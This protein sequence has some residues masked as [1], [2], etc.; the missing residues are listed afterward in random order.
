MPV[1]PRNVHVASKS[2]S[3]VDPE[4]RFLVAVTGASGVLYARRL[5]E[6]LG[7]RT[8]V[9]LAK[10]K[11]APP[12]TEAEFEIRYGTG[13]DTPFT[14]MVIEA[15]SKVELLDT[16]PLNFR[17]L[18]TRSLIPLVWMPWQRHML[19]PFLLPPELP[20]SLTRI[21]MRPSAAGAVQRTVTL[22]GLF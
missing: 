3:R 1:P 15:R 10:N 5:I 11:V 16:D 19:Q 9:K 18:R 2:P 4:S 22:P 17:P 12:F 8:R 14:E 13:V 21:A 20:V 6:I 7:H